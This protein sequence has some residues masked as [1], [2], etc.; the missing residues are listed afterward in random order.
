MIQSTQIF[1]DVRI[2]SIEDIGCMKI[3]TISSQGTKRDFVDLYFIL[4][5]SNISFRRLLEFF[6]LEY[7]AGSYHLYHVLKSLV[8]F[9][10]AEK[11]PDPRIQ[12]EFSW[13]NL[14]SFFEQQVK[15]LKIPF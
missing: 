12:V 10:D 8:Y 5:F 14:K 15:G 3:D 7:R 9:K 1:E 2:A 6:E 11:D 4:K 13:G